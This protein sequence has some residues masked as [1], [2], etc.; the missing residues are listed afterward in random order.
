MKGHAV[1]LVCCCILAIALG[2]TAWGQVTVTGVARV[3]V[4]KP[5]VAPAA[6]AAQKADP[7]LPVMAEPAKGENAKPAAEKA[8]AAEDAAR[9]KA[10]AAEK[11]AADKAKA[12]D[13]EKAKAAEKEAADKAKAQAQA[14]VAIRAGAFNAK[15]QRDNMR[16]SITNTPDG[17]TFKMKELVQFAME[18]GRMKADCTN[19][20]PSG[21]SKRLKIEGSDSVWMFNS[22]NNVGQSHF[23]LTRYDFD[24]ADE[25]FWQITVSCQSGPMNVLS[26]HAQGGDAC[27]ANRVYFTQQQ[28]NVTFNVMGRDNNRM[29]QI[30][31]ANAA[32]LTALRNAHPEA[33]RKFLVPLLRRITMQPIL[34]PGAGDVYRVFTEIPADAKVVS[35]VEALLP[36]LASP[37]P[38][39]RKKATDKLAALGP[40]GVLAAERMNAD[41]LAP[42]QAFRLGELVASQTRIIVDDPAEVAKDPDFLMDCLE[43]DDLAVRQAAR[44]SLAKLLNKPVDVDINAPA[45]KRAAAIDKYRAKIAREVKK[46]EKKDEKKEA[47]KAADPNQ[48]NVQPQPAIVPGV[49]RINV[50]Q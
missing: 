2:R 47:P 38:D 42:E 41:L 33:V 50:A 31:T 19:K 14:K 5:E 28:N 24:A 46:D 37:K 34:R 17:G 6:A 3:A 35:Q 30:L 11:E 45:A 27:E 20:I 39:V 44:D 32:D 21:Q 10:A 26:L 29:R 8:P 36:D 49:I 23:S 15:A 18:N 1:A 25:D 48:P 16:K 43:D 22:F 12:A 7:A 4:E 40:A 9:A 13:A